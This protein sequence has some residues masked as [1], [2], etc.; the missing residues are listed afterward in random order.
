MN[1]D[2]KCAFAMFARGERHIRYK[3]NVVS[4]LERIVPSADIVEIDAACAEDRLPDIPDSYA[5]WDKSIFMRL[6]IPLMDQFSGYDR[7]IWM[8]ADVDI[9]SDK[10]AGITNVD[11]SQ[12]GLAAAPD[13]KQQMYTSRMRRM[14]AGWRNRAYF[15]SG[16]LVMDLAKIDRDS[17]LKRISNGISRH[18]REGF[19]WP[20]QDILNGLFDIR[21]MDGRFNTIW[22]NVGQQV[23]PWLIHYTDGRGKNMLDNIIASKRSESMKKEKACFAVYAEGERFT[24]YKRNLLYTL[25]KASKGIDII[26]L[27]MSQACKHLTEVPKEDRPKFARLAIPLMEQF[28]CYDK[29]VWVDVD[30]DVVSDRF[31]EVVGVETSDDGLAAV[32]DRWQ[33]FCFKYMRKRFGSFDKPV[34]FNSGVLVMDLRKIDKDN[35][36][37]RVNA[38]VSDHL[39]KKFSN[40]D[41]DLI[42]E[43]FDVKPMDKRF[44]GQIDHGVFPEDSFLRH[45]LADDGHK[46]LDKLVASRRSLYDAGDELVS[47]VTKSMQ[48]TDPVDAVFVI[49]TGSHSNNDELRYALRN[50]DAHCK[51]IRDVYICGECPSWVDKSAVRHLQWPDRFSHAKDSNIIDKLRHACEYPGIAKKILFCSDDQFQTRECSWDDFE[52]RYLRVYKSND[53]WYAD[54]HR[55]WHTRLRKTLEREVQRRK[56]IGMKSGDVYYYQPHMWMQ[57]DR[58]AFMDYARWSEYDRRDDTIIASGYFNFAYAK[59]KEDFDHVFLDH[60][61]NSMPK[62]THVAYNDGCCDAVLKMLAQE[63]PEKCRFEVGY[64]V[65]GNAECGERCNVDYNPAPATDDELMAISDTISGIKSSGEHS[66]LLGDVCRAEELRIYGVR[67]WRTVWSDIISRFSSGTVSKRSDAADRVIRGYTSNPKAMRT[68]SESKPKRDVGVF[69]APGGAN[70]VRKSIRVALQRKVGNGIIL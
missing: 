37:K 35:W 64:D 38:G 66:E 57:I 59:G 5:G 3:D 26:E 51:F 25:R 36:I 58:D 48:E 30:V 14:F 2:M 34:Y 22:R 60:A 41:Q 11:T 46:A 24:E 9:V 68:I 39:K 55:L 28:R 45:Y 27:D 65:G 50:L 53:S 18:L 70:D 56:S 40:W 12:D 43:Y 21:M 52:P 67:G 19:R 69:R 32:A 29:V 54:K 62:A 6:A 8:D 63:F 1:N 16:V 4:E 31:C 23:K 47:G 13:I 15:N 33:D 49:G 42:N 10:F 20:D 44:N 17:W 7:V 61:V